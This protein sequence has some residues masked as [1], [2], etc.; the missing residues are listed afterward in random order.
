VSRQ[1]RGLK[2]TYTIEAWLRHAGGAGLFSHD[3]R[4]LHPVAQRPPIVD[5]DF[6]PRTGARLRILNI[7][8]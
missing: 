1:V 3:I 5:V 4:T 2:Y 7:A 6:S 8:A